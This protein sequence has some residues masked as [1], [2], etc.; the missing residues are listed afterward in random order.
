ME[1]ASEGFTGEQRKAHGIRFGASPSRHRGG[2]ALVPQM[3]REGR[4]DL[5]PRGEVMQMKEFD[6]FNTPAMR[7]RVSMDVLLRRGEISF[8]TP[9]MPKSKDEVDKQVEVVMAALARYHEWVSR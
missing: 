8:M 7:N 9:G 4:L 2:R 5:P 1:K 6:E 3:A